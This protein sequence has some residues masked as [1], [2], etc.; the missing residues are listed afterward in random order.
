MATFRSFEDIDSWNAARQFAQRIYKISSEGAFSKDYKLRDQING[1]SGSIMDNIAEGFER[2]GN[3]EF[4]QF[5]SVAKGSAGE[6]RSQLYRAFDR[7]YIAEQELESLKEEALKISRQISALMTYL[8]N[9]DLKGTKFVKEP[10]EPYLS[11][12]SNQTLNQK[13]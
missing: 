2:G 6:T 9:S 11:G 3:R 8:R 10:D 13:L 4:I 1:S 12:S 7:G 5:L